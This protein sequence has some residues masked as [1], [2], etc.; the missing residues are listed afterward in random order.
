MSSAAS[1]PIDHIDVPVPAP[2]ASIADL[3]KRHFDARELKIA[4]LEAEV[5]SLREQL[6]AARAN[7]TRPA[8]LPKLPAQA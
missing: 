3:V 2:R 8:R 6:K 1:A 5:K 7:R 4:K